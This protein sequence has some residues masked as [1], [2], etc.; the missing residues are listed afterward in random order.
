MF[1]LFYLH[2]VDG[3]F[4]DFS[5]ISDHYPKISENSPKVVQRSRERCEHF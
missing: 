4:D 3:V 5:N 2:T 1:F